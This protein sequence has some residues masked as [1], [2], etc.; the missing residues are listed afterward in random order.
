MKTKQQ[1][2]SAGQAMQD[3]C[4]SQQEFW[5]WILYIATLSK[6]ITG[7]EFSLVYV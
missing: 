3:H 6:S 2:P 5:I 4:S 1:Q 7:R